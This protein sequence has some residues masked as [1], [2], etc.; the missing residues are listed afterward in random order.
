MLIQN[1]VKLINSIPGGWVRMAQFRRISGGF[2]VSFSIHQGK[3]GKKIE[4]WAIRCRGVHEA[5]ISEMDGG[6]LGLYPSDHPAARQYVTRRAELRWPRTCD[7]T[8]VLAA[9]FRAHVETVDDWIPLDGY[10]QINTPWNGTSFLPDFA[11]VSGKNFVCRGP[12]FLLLAYASAL[13]AIGERVELRVRSSAKPRL[14]RPR[15][16]HFGASQIVADVF[17]AERQ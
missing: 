5:K 1:A 14:I 2:E 4:Q 3:R 8:K 10:L 16:L 17:T 6:G 13:K 9:L 12:D 15:V 7:E 11:P